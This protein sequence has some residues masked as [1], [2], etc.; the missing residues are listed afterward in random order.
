MS[1][2]HTVAGGFLD[3]EFWSWFTNR[4]NELGQGKI[5]VQMFAAESLVKGPDMYESVRDGIAEMS[6]AIIPY[7]SGLIKIPTVIELPFTFVNYETSHKAWNDMLDAGLMDY[8]EKK[9]NVHPVNLLLGYPY[10]IV[11]VKPINTVADVKGLKMRAPGGM[12]AKAVDMMGGVSVSMTTAELYTSLQRGIVEGGIIGE[13]DFV[14]YRY[15]ELAKYVTRVDM[16]TT[17][18]PIV[19]NMQVWEKLPKDIQNIIHQAGKEA[20]DN[21]ERAWVLALD[22][23]KDTVYI[24]EGV[25]LIIPSE[26]VKAEFRDA[27]KPLIENWPNEYGALEDGLGYKLYDILMASLK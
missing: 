5:E 1:K 14:S 20:Q 12:Y 16:G 15:Y 26:A 13:E 17:G 24:E 18:G 22:E 10:P 6:T 27:V 2:S 7:E 9:L 4:V 8:Y 23:Y 25:E 19:V 3:K 21:V 11:G